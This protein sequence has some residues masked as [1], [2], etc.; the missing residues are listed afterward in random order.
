MRYNK[1]KLLIYNYDKYILY[2][3]VNIMVIIMTEFDTIKRAQMYIEKMAKGINPLDNKPIPEQD[4]INNARISKCLSFVSGILCRVIENG[5]VPDPSSSKP[6]K[7]KKLPFE[8]TDEARDRIEY[9]NHPISISELTRRI[10]AAVCNEQM[11]A[12]RSTSVFS[13]LVSTELLEVI[14]MEDL[15]ERKYPTSG[16]NLMGIT[17]EMRES[18]HGPYQAIVINKEAQTFIVDNIEAILAHEEECLAYQGTP[19]TTDQDKLLTQMFYAKKSVTEIAHELKRA[20]T[21]IRSRIKKLGLY[22]FT[23]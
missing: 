14:Q 10:N 23:K 8:I 5:G 2:R 6:K 17:C 12:F 11:A 7:I 3:I 15:K 19:W 22:H 9:S 1:E 18:S 21:S 13:W 16:G 20:T 4:L